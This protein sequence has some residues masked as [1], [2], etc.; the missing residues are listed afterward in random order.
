MGR[1]GGVAGRASIFIRD[2]CGTDAL[3]GRSG[4]FVVLLYEVLARRGLRDESPEKDS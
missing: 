4:S 3:T 1:D 2:F